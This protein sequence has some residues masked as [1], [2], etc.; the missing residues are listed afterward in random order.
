MNVVS[1]LN[2]ELLKQ[3]FAAGKDQLYREELERCKEM[4]RSY[5]RTENCVAVLSDMHSNT[6]YIYYGGFSGML[7]L[8]AREERVDSI[9]EESILKHIHPDDLSEKYL[10]ELRFFHFIRHQP[11]SKRADY[12]LIHALRMK[13]AAGDY[14]PALHRL[15]YLSALSKESV[16]LALCLYSPLLFEVP[17]RSVVVNSATGQLLT[18]GKRT[19]SQI[20]SAREKQVLQLIDKGMTSKG[21]ADLLSISIYTVSR[22]RQAILEKL[23]VRNAIEACR[24]A[25]SIG[26]I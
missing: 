4:A 14:F 25:K 6:S 1:Q 18:L 24:V 7:G 16:R 5:A 9:W 8:D 22:H 13:N 23:Q 2:D 15:F 10:Q 26:I 21:I 3:D 12:Y 20:L 11:R 17:G 19:D